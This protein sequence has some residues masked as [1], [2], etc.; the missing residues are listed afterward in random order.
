MTQRKTAR[1]HHFLPVFYLAGFTETGRR[2]G[3]LYVFDYFRDRHYI[4]TPV[5]VAK[6]RDYYRISDHPESDALEA[7]MSRM[8]D[9]AALALKT[10]IA[11]RR[12]ASRAQ[13]P[14]LLAFVALIFARGPRLRE[15]MGRRAAAQ[16][17]RDLISGTMTEQRWNAIRSAEISA[18]APE[19]L[20]P[21]YGEA[22]RMCRAGRWG[23]PLP[24][25]FYREYLS[26]AYEEISKQLLQRPWLLMRCD[27]SEHGGFICSDTPLST[28]HEGPVGV[29]LERLNDPDILVTCPLSRELALVSRYGKKGGNYEATPLIVADVNKRSQLASMGMLYSATGEFL[30]RRGYRADSS[31]DYFEYIRRQRAKGII[32]P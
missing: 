13:L 3:R 1:Q 9:P 12:I 24:L 26:V 19:R 5:K 27:A 6:E 2:D 8:E 7:A 22:G 4:S 25:T 10:V 29:S 30:L 31:R 20:F 15:Q 32:R 14:P 18:G 21:S 16:A 23:P 11:E 28:L 17:H